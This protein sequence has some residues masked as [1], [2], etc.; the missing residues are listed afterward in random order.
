MSLYKSVINSTRSNR[1]ARVK[2][3]DSVRTIFV[4]G[5]YIVFGLVQRARSWPSFFS[6]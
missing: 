1:T 2:L 5:N 4:G 3:K 6:I